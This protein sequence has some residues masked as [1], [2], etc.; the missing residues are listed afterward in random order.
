[1]AFSDFIKTVKNETGDA[2]EITK[3]K[4]KISKEKTNIK[5]NYEKIGE[6]VY[7]QYA[8]TKTGDEGIMEFLKNIDASR[9]AIS[10]Y[11]EEISKVKNVD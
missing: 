5:D 1:M 10:G 9:E 4:A 6:Y 11:N 7:K 2:I 8:K 3:L